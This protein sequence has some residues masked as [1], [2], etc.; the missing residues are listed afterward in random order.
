MNKQDQIELYKMYLE[1]CMEDMC[2]SNDM[3]FDIDIELSMFNF[4][5]PN[6]KINV[7]IDDSSVGCII[8]MI[9]HQEL[10]NK[11]DP[12]SCLS[13]IGR[14]IINIFEQNG[15]AKD[16]VISFTRSNGCMVGV[17]T[18]EGNLKC[19]QYQPSELQH[20]VDTI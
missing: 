3:D 5:I 2:E 13:M 8:T 14:I 20:F 7:K 4:T 1:C 12:T 10:Y 6:V 17:I 11:S 19:G 9:N 16:H 15:I 18:P